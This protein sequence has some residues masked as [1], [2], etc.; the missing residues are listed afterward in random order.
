MLSTNTTSSAASKAFGALTRCLNRSN[1]NYSATL[2]TFMR[3][4]GLTWPISRQVRFFDVLDVLLDLSVNWKVSPWFDVRLRYLHSRSDVDRVVIVFGEPGHVTLL[5]MEQIAALD[6]SAYASAVRAIVRLLSSSDNG[7]KVA[8]KTSEGSSEIELL[9]H[10]ETALRETIVSALGEN[11][12]DDSLLTLKESGSVLQNVSFEE[13]KALLDKHLGPKAGGFAISPD[14]TVLLLCKSLFARLSA[15]MSTI[16]VGRLLDALG[17][18]FAY[19]YAWI[20]NPLLDGLPPTEV[21]GPEGDDIVGPF[22][23]VLCFAAVLESF[24]I[25]PAAPFFVRK[26]PATERDKVAVVLNATALTLV[27]AIE[28]SRSISNVTKAKARAKI[29][30]HTR[31][32]LWPAQPFLSLDAL[33]SLYARFPSADA[34]NFYTSWLESRKAQRAALSERSYGTLMTAKLR[35]YAE[36][37]RYVYSLN[38]IALGLAAVFP[39]SYHLQGSAVMTYASLGFQF[40]RK[41]I[42]TIDLRGRFLDYDGNSTG[43]EWWERKRKCRLD[44]A[45]TL[46]RRRAITDL[47]ALDVALA[48][49]EKVSASDQS[50]LR[51]K[52]LEKQTPEQTFY[53]SYCNRFCGKHNARDMC[54]LAMNGSQFKVAFDCPWRV[55]NRG[56]LLF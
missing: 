41:L 38:R 25:A 18:T 4:R 47:L 19:S 34:K 17:W 49:M 23:R 8:E 39:P 37:I 32:T 56:C 35:W 1:E 46:K 33:D 12:V 26:F 48:T 11:E 55:V 13:W 5:R 3:E 20:G 27:A 53:V 42:S 29:L 54:D 50:Q 52:L 22:T 28:T 51:L 15:V 7:S 36:K 6:K 14:T 10:D 44:K 30:S 2:A 16:P 40:A 24:G 21:R 31:Q 9:R 43:K 45:R